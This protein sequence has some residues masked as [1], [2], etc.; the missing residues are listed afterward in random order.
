MVAAYLGKECQRKKDK[1][2]ECKPGHGICLP[3]D[4]FPLYF[5]LAKQ[6]LCFM[7]GLV[8]TLH[9]ALAL[10]DHDFVLLFELGV[11]G[12]PK[13]VTKLNRKQ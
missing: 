10:G 11:P 7:P 6:I 13:K 9:N 1:G 2:D 3:G 5:E 8:I 4:S 12:L